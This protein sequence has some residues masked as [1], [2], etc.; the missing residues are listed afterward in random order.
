MPVS[1]LQQTTTLATPTRAPSQSRPHPP[2][3]KTSRVSRPTNPKSRHSRKKK[4]IDRGRGRKT[5]RLTAKAKQTDARTRTPR[6]IRAPAP[7]PKRSVTFKSTLR[8]SIGSAN[9]RRGA[10]AVAMERIR[11][12]IIASSRGRYRLINAGRWCPVKFNTKKMRTQQIP[13]PQITKSFSRATC[14]PKIPTSIFR[15]RHIHPIPAAT[16]TSIQ[17]KTSNTS[18]SKPQLETLKTTGYCSSSKKAAATQNTTAATWVPKRIQVWQ[19]R[20]CRASIRGR[21][22]IYPQSTNIPTT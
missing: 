10:M 4:R 8:S 16:T 20:V 6:R 5:G 18:S 14:A 11:S 13:P 15:C 2:S 9:C 22:N 1:Q 7:S 12:L 19:L 21:T 3:P 17:V